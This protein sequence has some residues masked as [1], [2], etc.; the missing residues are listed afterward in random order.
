MER[1]VDIST[2]GRHL[3]AY[4]GFLVVSEQRRE[5]GRIPL[6][7]VAAVI[8]HAHGV[9]WSTNLAVA[10]AERGAPL[11]TVHSARASLCREVAARVAAAYRLTARAPRRRKRLVIQRIS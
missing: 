3:A 1:V 7:D 10:L 4:R 9:T 8:V 11:V 6:D 2:D 5:V